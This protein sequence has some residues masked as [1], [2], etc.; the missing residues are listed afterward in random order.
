M[1]YTEETIQIA[2]EG[3]T[4][5]D[6]ILVPYIC[7]RRKPAAPAKKK[8]YSERASGL[9]GRLIGA[10]FAVLSVLWVFILVGPK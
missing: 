5:A 9:I 10:G 7:A 2:E 6:P 8:V 1:R 4:F 3:R